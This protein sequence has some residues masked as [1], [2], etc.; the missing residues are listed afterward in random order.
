VFLN[1]DYATI[2][3]LGS[4]YIVCIVVKFST[5][6]GMSSSLVCIVSFFK[7]RFESD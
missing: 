6:Q 3:I 1:L 7:G 5:C 2:I 4:F